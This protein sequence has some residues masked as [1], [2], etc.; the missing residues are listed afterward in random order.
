MLSRLCRHFP[1][2][3]PLRVLWE[4]EHDPE[5]WMVQIAEV[6]AYEDARDLVARMKSEDDLPK[7]DPMVDLAVEHR[8]DRGHADMLARLGK[9]AAG[10][11]AV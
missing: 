2:I 6:R 4:L 9:K 1:G 8:L 7:D 10:S 5:Q 11:E 3:S